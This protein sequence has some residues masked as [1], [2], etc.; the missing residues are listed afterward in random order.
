M[1]T[2][3]YTIAAESSVRISITREGDFIKFL[4]KILLLR[5]DAY[6]NLHKHG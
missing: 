1:N 3:L 2:F 4:C 6:E 5:V